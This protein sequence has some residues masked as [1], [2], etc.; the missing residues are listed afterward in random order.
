MDPALDMLSRG[1]MG[2]E[3]AL[4]FLDRTSSIYV[5]DV[6]DSSKPK[7]YG[8]WNFIHQALN[9]LERHERNFGSSGGASG[10]GNIRSYVQLLAAMSQRVARR[11]PQSDRKLVSTC[12]ENA[13]QY[14]ASANEAEALIVLNAEI[15]EIVMGRIAAMVFDFSFHNPN[16]P[17]LS[18]FSDP[19]AMEGL[20]SVLS[21]NA[22]SSGPQAINH[23]MLE[24]IIPSVQTLPPFAVACVIFH[25]GIEATRKVSPAGTKDLLQRMSGAIMAIVLAPVLCDAVQESGEAR[26]VGSN[27]ER[28]SR[29][30]AVSI[31]AIERWCSAT[32]LSLPQIKHVCSKVNVNIVEVLSDAMYSDSQLVMEAV[33]ELMERVVLTRDMTTDRMTQTRYIMEVDETKFQSIS[34]ADLERIESKEMEAI[35]QELVSAIGLQRFR[36]AERQANGDLAGCRCLTRIAVAVCK[37]AMHYSDSEKLDASASGM[38]DLL[39]KSAAHQSVNICGVAL[40]ALTE[41]AAKDETFALRLLPILQHRAIVPHVLDSGN[42]SLAASEVCGVDT[43]EFESFR[44]T[45]LNMALKSCYRKNEDY[46]MNSC[47]V[48]VE[49]FCKAAPTV[50]TSFQLEAALY[51]LG[52]VAGES[53]AGGQARLTKEFIAENVSSDM[54]NIKKNQLARCSQLLEM[55]PVCMTANPLTLSQACR[56]IGKHVKWYVAN[57]NDVAIDIAAELCLSAMAA[58]LVLTEEA[59]QKLMQEMSVSPFSEAALALHYLLTEQPGHFMTEQALKALGIAWEACYM[60]SNQAGA[61]TIEAREALCDGLCHVLA[62]LPRNQQGKPF[63]VLFIPTL[64]CLRTMTKLAD[65]C[66]ANSQGNDKKLDSILVRVSDEIRIL[67]VMA[68]TYQKVTLRSSVPVASDESQGEEPFLSVLRKAWPSVSHV[69]ESFNKNE[70]VSLALRKFLIGCLPH[71]LQRG[72]AMSLLKEL[73]SLSESILTNSNGSKVALWPVAEFVTE[74]INTYGRVVEQHAIDIVFSSRDANA[75]DDETGKLLEGLVMSLVEASRSRLGLVWIGKHQGQGEEPCESQTAPQPEP[76]KSPSIEGLSV[77]FS[78]LTACVRECPTF[79]V[80]LRVSPGGTGHQ[81]TLLI[82]RAVDAACAAL[83]ETD[84]ETVASAIIFL[85]SAI[86]LSVSLSSELIKETMTKALSRD[87]KGMIMAVVDG[88]C[89]S[90]HHSLLAPSADLLYTAVRSFPPAEMHI[91]LLPA[92]QQARFRLGERAQRVALQILDG[93]SQGIIPLSTLKELVDDVWDLHQVDDVEAI[94]DSDIVA[95]FA[96]DKYNVL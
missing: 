53:I 2:D 39:L 71:D 11:S 8:G 17:H 60:A 25:L 28:H 86:K 73:C 84:V 9:E 85:D 38:L 79:L 54:S 14:N 36:F 44:S 56:F 58:S 34:V 61:V 82:G 23:F 41:L 77:I 64:E 6:T 95:R 81:D 5:L 59:A 15:R 75:S 22:V 72:E 37:A 57:G 12:V 78:V 63:Q 18:A 30:A 51:C 69:A 16:G 68:E 52:A 19:V 13:A 94:A 27:H 26:G 20:C 50:K 89:G 1:L 87:R 46:Y 93:C 43:F 91:C 88:I 47:S 33:A 90:Y 83:I 96:A 7:T 92:V 24:W 62:T 35:V 40:D 74:L 32:D 66:N 65:E 3:N 21:A 67:S 4:A 31:R 10:T 70:R 49:E 48:A 76:E 42:P 80:H 29:V 45:V 55:K